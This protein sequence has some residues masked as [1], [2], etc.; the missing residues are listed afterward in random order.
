MPNAKRKIIRTRLADIRNK[1]GLTQ[2]ELSEKLRVSKEMIQ[3]YEQGKS[4]LPID[5]AMFLSKTYNCSL[6]WI[7]CNTSN[8][9]KINQFENYTKEERLSFLVDIR[10]FLIC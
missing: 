6:D 10:D 2:K 8:N 5:F 1:Y 7:Y 3:N 9:D 4:N